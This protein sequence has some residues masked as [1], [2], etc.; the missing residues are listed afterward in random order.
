MPPWAVKALCTVA[1]AIL[2][3]LYF[4]VLS[5]NASVAVQAEQIKALREEFRVMVGEWNKEKETIRRL[6]LESAGR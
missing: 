1:V 6:E 2:L 5:V 4:T 3:H